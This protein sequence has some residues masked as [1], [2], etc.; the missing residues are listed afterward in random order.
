MQTSNLMIL[1]QGLS[2]TS[3]TELYGKKW[4]KTYLEN[5]H[6]SIKDYR[7]RILQ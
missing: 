3:K 4:M 2:S 5:Y 1:Y 7:Y 6:N